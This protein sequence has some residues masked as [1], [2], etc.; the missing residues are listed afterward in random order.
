MFWEFR[1]AA[2]GGEDEF[3]GWKKFHKATGVWPRWSMLT[4]L[5]VMP[6]CF[7]IGVCGIIE[8]LKTGR[9]LI[10]YPGLF[11]SVVVPAIVWFVS[12]RLANT[13]DVKRA[14]RNRV[15]PIVGKTLKHFID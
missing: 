13:A 14:E 1:S 8:S 2:G 3:R 12:R 6:L 15:S 9:L 4:T 11:A 10:I 5:V 7:A